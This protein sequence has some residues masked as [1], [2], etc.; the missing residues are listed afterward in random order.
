MF[1]FSHPHSLPL[2]SPFFSSPFRA[3][4]DI[5]FFVNL[6]AGAAG[7]FAGSTAL[8]ALFYDDKIMIANVGDCQVNIS[9]FPYL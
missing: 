2:P 1:L 9:I 6:Q 8:T 3:Y 7:W 5:D 4:T